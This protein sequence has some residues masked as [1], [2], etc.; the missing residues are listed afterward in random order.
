M[1][2]TRPRARLL[3]TD[4]DNTL[5]DWFE[6]WHSSF[7]ALLAEVVSISGLPAEVLERD[8]R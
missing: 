1:E 6:I 4:L 2:V 5:Y 3:V 7:S 8:A